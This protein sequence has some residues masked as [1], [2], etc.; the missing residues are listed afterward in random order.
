VGRMSQDR[1]A[2]ARD[3]AFAGDVHEPALEQLAQVFSRLLVLGDCVTLRGDLGAGKT[4]F[5]R[6]LVRA[7][8]DDPTHEVPS[9][10]FALRQD[11]ASARG[12]VVHLDLYRLSDVRELDELGFDETADRAITIIEWPE[13]AEAALPGSRFEIQL[14]NATRP[15]ARHVTV[16]GLGQAAGRLATVSAGWPSR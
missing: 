13:R 15:D 7:L 11:Y 8:L 9:P 1:S 12:P 5:A 6:A 16:I 2:A 14:H 3:I 4:T 10:T